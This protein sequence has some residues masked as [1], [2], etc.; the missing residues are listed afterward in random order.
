MTTNNQD[1]QEAQGGGMLIGTVEYPPDNP[2]V[3][4]V[5]FDEDSA[6]FVRASLMHEHDPQDLESLTEWLTRDPRKYWNCG[7]YWASMLNTWLG[8]LDGDLRSWVVPAEPAT[9]VVP[10]IASVGSLRED[11]EEALATLSESAYCIRSYQYRRR[12]THI[13]NA[14]KELV[15][16]LEH[17]PASLLI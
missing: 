4:G 14:I 16:D 11:L 17:D 3:Y 9:E 10:Q 2:R 13:T 8:K 5:A 6:M 1:Q 7:D 12:V 15:D